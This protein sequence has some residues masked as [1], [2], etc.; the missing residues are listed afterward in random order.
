MQLPKAQ[1]ACTTFTWSNAMTTISHVLKPNAANNIIQGWLLFEGDVYY[2]EA[3]SMWL[4]FTIFQSSCRQVRLIMY[5]GVLIYS[6]LFL[7]AKV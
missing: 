6:K 1:A 4:L 7:R 3:P 2:A 5:V